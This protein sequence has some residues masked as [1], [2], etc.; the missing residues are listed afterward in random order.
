MFSGSFTLITDS[1]G[2]VF[3]DR[4][5][6]RFHHILNYLRSGT[7]PNFD[8][9]WKYEEIMEEADFFN[10]LEL[11]E[12]VTKKVENLH[13]KRDFDRNNMRPCKIIFTPDPSTPFP[14]NINESSSNRDEQGRIQLTGHFSLEEDF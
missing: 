6:R 3:I 5:G 12:M 11:K 13:T 4:D 1:D 7:I 2:Y 9:I 8:D 10:L 14:M